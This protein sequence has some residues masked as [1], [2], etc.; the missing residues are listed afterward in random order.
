MDTDLRENRPRDRALT[1]DL[2]GGDTVYRLEQEILLGVGGMLAL[3]AVGEA[4][5]V[6]HL[7]E[8][9]AAF[10]ALE[11]LRRLHQKGMSDQ[12]ARAEVRRTTV[13]TTH[14]PVAAGHDRFAPELVLR[15]LG[16]L[17]KRAGLTRDAPARARPGESERRA[18]KASA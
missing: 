15:Y 12:A 1:D 9:H 7:N 11:R 17:G 5:T 18:R 3:D 13:F 2:Y 14:T 6:F 10:C 4:P 16:E 8:G